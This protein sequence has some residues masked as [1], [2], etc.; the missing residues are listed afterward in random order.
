MRFKVEFNAT[1]QRIPVE[2]G[3]VQTVTKLVGGEQYSGPL[4]VTP[5][6]QKQELPTSGKVLTDNVVVHP[7]PKEY[8]LVTYDNRKIIRIT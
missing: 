1:E 4:E 3:T 7:I 5:T 6:T 2:F 8:G